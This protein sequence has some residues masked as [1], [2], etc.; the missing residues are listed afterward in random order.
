MGSI[1]AN[2]QQIT[3][4]LIT[5][6]FHIPILLSKDLACKDDIGLWTP[7]GFRLL[8][9]ETAGGVVFSAYFR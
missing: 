3:T 8:V 2:T 6:H 4:V 7:R 1:I 5:A 9:M